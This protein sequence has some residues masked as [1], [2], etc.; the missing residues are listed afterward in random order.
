[1]DAETGGIAVAVARVE[2]NEP[3]AEEDELELVVVGEEVDDEEEAVVEEV[4]VVI[5]DVVIVH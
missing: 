2:V 5:E 1:M 3:V 4:D